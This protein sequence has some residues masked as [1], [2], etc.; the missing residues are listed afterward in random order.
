M[1]L[2]GAGIRFIQGSDKMYQDLKEYYWCPGMKTD[3]A[4]YVN[5]CLTC[6]KFKA[7]HQRPSVLLEQPKI[8]EWK[9]DHITMDFVTKFPRTSS[10]HDSIWVI[11]DRLTKSAHFIPI[12]EDYPLV[13]LARLY[14]KE[15]VSLHGAP[16]SIISDRDP[17]FASHFWK[18]LQQ[19]LGTCSI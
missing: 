7:E 18:S 16:L 8:P 9:W 10:G 1:K 12:R 19:A 2:I 3:V 17:R 15:I 13:K 4:N 5:K 6:S 11:V 14:L